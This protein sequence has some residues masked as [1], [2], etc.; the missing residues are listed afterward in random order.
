M[1]EDIVRIERLVKVGEKS[2]NGSIINWDSYRE[3]LNSERVQ[4][5]LNMRL[6][7]AEY[8]HPKLY[9]GLDRAVVIG[10]DNIAGTITKIED[11]YIELYPINETAKKLI[12]NNDVRSAMRYLA[13][14]THD[15]DGNK[16]L[17][18]IKIITF[19]LIKKG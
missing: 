4:R 2:R 15:E 16:Y 11:D 3:S 1:D 5:L 18:D 19:D 9:E 8:D 17:T 12:E 13:K 7:H 10:F 6:L 14:E